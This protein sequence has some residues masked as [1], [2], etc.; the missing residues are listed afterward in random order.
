MNLKLKADYPGEDWVGAIGTHRFE[1][2]QGEAIEVADQALADWL[3][4]QTWRQPVPR[5]GV[6]GPPWNYETRTLFEECELVEPKEEAEAEAP[7]AAATE[8]KTRKR[9]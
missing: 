8:T 7:E 5:D 4:K 9:G 1:I 6:S 3:L 2:K